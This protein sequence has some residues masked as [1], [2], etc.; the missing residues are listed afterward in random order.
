MTASNIPSSTLE[1][2]KSSSFS[3]L[4]DSVDIV[5]CATRALHNASNTVDKKKESA[6]ASEGDI[7]EVSKQ[8]NVS[9]KRN[10]KAAQ[11]EQ[12]TQIT[13]EKSFMHSASHYA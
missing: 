8:G 3:L 6:S 5:Q 12:Q 4:F 7:I 13:S 1:S 9:S 2:F 10:A 11:S